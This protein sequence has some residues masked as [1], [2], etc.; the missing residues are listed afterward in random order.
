MQGIGNDFVLID[1]F[2]EPLVLTTEQIKYIANRNFGVGCDQVLLLEPPK[3]DESDVYYRIFNSDG[4]EVSQCGNGARCSAIY[5]YDKGLVKKQKMIAETK[6]GKLVLKIN[7]DNSVTVNMGIP[8]FEPKDIPINYEKKMKNYSL[9]LNSENI[10]F[11]AVSIG[12]PHA[13]IF[14]DDIELTSIEKIAIKIQQDKIF[15]EGVNVSFVQILDRKKIKLRVFERGVGET[16]SCGSGACASVVVASQR[17]GLEEN[18][19]AELRGGVLKL[20]WAGEGKP[21]F[22]NGP[23]STVYDGEIEL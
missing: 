20:S 8:K 18:V 1:S 17:G 3:D 5:L 4:S 15:P 13:I 16:L 22:M 9:R 21:I 12:N 2:S 6:S 10:E 11:G 23:V 7:K 19:E 14:V